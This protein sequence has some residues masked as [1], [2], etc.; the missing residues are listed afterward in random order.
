MQ[1]DTGPGL[2]AHSHFVVAANGPNFSVAG[3]G[4]EH[5]YIN[6]LVRRIRQLMCIVKCGS[7]SPDSVVE[8]LRI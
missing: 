2:A 5:I 7:P 8:A 6:A 4:H 3:D 1:L